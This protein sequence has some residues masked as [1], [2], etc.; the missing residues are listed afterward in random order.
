M[1]ISKIS[2]VLND[3]VKDKIFPGAVLSVSVDGAFP[4]QTAVGNFSY[5]QNNPVVSLTTIFDIA[6]VTKPIVATVA[7]KLIKTGKIK[8]DGIVG[9]YISQLTGTNVGSNIT[10]WHL[11]THTSSI[12]LQ[13]SSLTGDSVSKE[14]FINAMVTY[15][16]KLNPG[17]HVEYANVNTFLLGEIIATV[18]GIPLD[19]FIKREITGPLEMVDTIFNPPV[20]VAERIAPTEIVNNETIRGVVREPSARKI[21]GIAGHAGLFSTVSDLDNF[22]TMWTEGGMFKGKQLLDKDIIYQALVN[23]TPRLNKASCLGWHMDNPEY[24]G[25]LTPKGMFFHPGFTG[26]IIAGS[27][28]QKCRIIFLSNCTFPHRENLHMKNQFL[29][30]LFDAIFG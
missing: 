7:L 20:N 23:Q 17:T 19:V 29:K 2:S 11:L 14:V 3:G 22:L 15:N 9:E 30:K 27:I 4:Y 10:V 12:N 21:G 26:T 1:N 25:R 8:L 24:L 13:M 18:S 16:E 5:D 6:S 28:S